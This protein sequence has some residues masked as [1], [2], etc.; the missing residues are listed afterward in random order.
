MSS[1]KGRKKKSDTSKYWGLVQKLREYSRDEVLKILQRYSEKEM[2]AI[3]EEY[4]NSYEELKRLDRN[5]KQRIRQVS[6]GLLYNYQN[7]DKI[8]LIGCSPFEF[9]KMRGSPSAEDLKN[10]HIDHIFPFSWFDLS[11]EDHIK[12]CCHYTN[13]QYLSSSDNFK[14][15]NSYAG[16]PN[17]IIVYKHAFDVDAHVSERLVIINALK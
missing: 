17:S 14:K 3:L 4:N 7:T 2:L 16:S 1:L 11:D 5:Y 15:N 12:V 9:W 6:T 8:K 10:L 13:L